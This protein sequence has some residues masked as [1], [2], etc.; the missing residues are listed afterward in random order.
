MK[1]TN[2]W[3]QRAITS[4]IGRVNKSRVGKVKL[5]KLGVKIS[6]LSRLFEGRI[7][8]GTEILSRES[9]ERKGK[10]CSVKTCNRIL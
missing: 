2:T 1:R 7:D 10:K 5:T 4:R 9:D 6:S 3:N 8:D